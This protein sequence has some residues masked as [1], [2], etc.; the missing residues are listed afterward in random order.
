[1]T[2]RTLPAYVYQKPKGLY[3]QRR[4]WPTVRIEADPGTPAFALEYA[5]IL[6][7]ARVQSKT[8]ARDFNALVK[9]YIA[10]PRYAKLAPR[11]ARDYEKVLDWVKGKIGTPPVDGMQ[12]KD[13][14]RAR[15]YR[16][17]GGLGW[18]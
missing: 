7:G 8:T 18:P 1:M 14:I 2:K 5:A 13:V 3:F 9:S 10:S 16:K 6:N 17:W 11:T 4:G 12:R 15:R